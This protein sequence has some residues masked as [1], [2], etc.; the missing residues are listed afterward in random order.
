[1]ESRLVRRALWGNTKPSLN[2]YIPSNIVMRACR[3]QHRNTARIPPIRPKNGHEVSTCTPCISCQ[4][5]KPCIRKSIELIAE[6]CQHRSLAVSV[7][8]HFSISAY[9]NPS[10]MSRDGESSHRLMNW[11]RNAKPSSSARC[12]VSRCIYRS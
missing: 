11:R 7:S 6:C 5:P 9:Y 4:H 2:S 1:M 12:I 3:Q 10:A 8:K